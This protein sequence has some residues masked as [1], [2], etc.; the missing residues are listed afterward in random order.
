[1]AAELE[2]SE[3]KNAPEASQR[4]EGGGEALNGPQNGLDTSDKHQSGSEALIDHSNKVDGPAGHEEKRQAPWEKRKPKAP[5]E[6]EENAYW[7]EQDRVNYESHME[8]EAR[9]ERKEKRWAEWRKEKAAARASE[10]RTLIEFA[11][12]LGPPPVL[13][14]ELREAYDELLACMMKEYGVEDNFEAILIRRK[15]DSSWLTQRY[16][17]HMT[18][19]IGH[20]CPQSLDAPPQRQ[21]THA[22]RKAGAMNEVS[23]ALPVVAA[24][25]DRQKLE[26]EVVHAEIDEALNHQGMEIA[27]NHSLKAEMSLLEDLDL[28]INNGIRR[29]LSCDELLERYREMKSLR[30]EAAKS[31]M[32]SM[33]Q[34]VYSRVE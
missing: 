2:T 7:E 19:A 21:I 28:L 16:M 1:M 24:G 12:R 26:V 10:L 20:N 23:R 5:S 4:L 33:R 14:N 22:G 34:L 31:L 13:S 32:A 30:R 3:N 9:A 6:E 8:R 18:I 25:S 11:N 27:H 17:R 29:E 15:V